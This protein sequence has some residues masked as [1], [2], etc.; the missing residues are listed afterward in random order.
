MN[1]MF[2]S[3]SNITR[4]DFTN[5][6]SS[7]VTIMTSTFKDCISLIEINLSNFEISNIKNMS[8]LFYNC[9]KLEHIDL[10]SF[11]TSQI[12]DIRHMFAN[13]KS[14]ISINLSNFKASNL[15]ITACSFYNC[16]SLI[17]VDLSNLEANG[18]QYMGSM[19]KNCFSLKSVDLSKLGTSQVKNM[20]FMF[21]NCISLTSLN[22]SNFDGSSVTWIESMFDGCKNLEYINLKNFHINSHINDINYDNI[23][24]GIPE[25]IFICLD[26][27]REPILSLL[28]RNYKCFSI[29]PTDN[30]SLNKKEMINLTEK[31]KYSCNNTYEY[32]YENNNKC[33][34]DCYCISC[35]DNYYP[36]EDEPKFENLYFNCYQNPE[37]YYLDIAFY[38][39]CYKTCKT[40][41]MEGNNIN[42]N[43]LTCNNNFPIEIINSINKI[44]CY[45]NCSYYYFFYENC[46][47]YCEI[48]DLLTKKCIIKP[49]TNKTNEKEII[50]IQDTVI[51]NINKS[52]TSQNYDSSNIDNGEE[53]II[54]YNKLK[55]TLTATDNQKNNIDNNSTTIDL[56]ECEDVL[57]YI[58]NISNNK[59][60]YLLKIEV[61]QDK[62]KIPKIEYEVYYKANETNL[63]KLN[64]NYCKNCRANLLIPIEIN[65]NLDI[66]NSSS[67]YYNDICYTTKSDSGTDITLKDR[68]NDFIL[69][70][71]TVCQD[72]CIFAD[73]DK[74]TKKVKCSCKIKEPSTST[75]DMNIDTKKLL[76]NFMDIKNIANIGILVCYKKLLS[77]QGIIKN[78]GCLIVISNIILHFIFIILFYYNQ[79]K[80]L[81]TK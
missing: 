18:L 26:E 31:C 58:Y 53:E 57:R 3:C 11:D 81:K 63:V 14:L 59:K 12:I 54:N 21:Y 66:Y 61:E 38:K 17:S 34:N 30:P 25:N 2:D 13:C 44:N 55:I 22:L 45:E 47:D 29:D 16:Y 10:S 69:K 64:L 32:I 7:N 1:C 40:C 28:I 72:D 75:A 70:N 9:N 41:E 39:L 79:F 76:K 5:F 4:I 46:T 43:C 19:F 49:I 24:R 50:D 51:H 37:G 67:R 65:E 71:K 27:I 33:Y 73:Y 68:Q 74:N 60:I 80:N 62:M 56:S 15:K 35:K 78:I 42:H 6:D 52:F 48:N 23:F 8:F 77:L 20:D 36:K